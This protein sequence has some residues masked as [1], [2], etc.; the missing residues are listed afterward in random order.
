MIRS[1]NLKVEYDNKI[2]EGFYKYYFS[3]QLS[4][5]EKAVGIRNVFD[6][7]YMRTNGITLN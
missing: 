4:G 5:T 1:D 2:N 7:I 3:M 6:R